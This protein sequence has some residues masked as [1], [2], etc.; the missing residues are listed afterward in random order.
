M[1]KMRKI[2]FMF[3]VIL[4]VVHNNSRK[5]GLKYPSDEAVG[6][7]LEILPILKLFLAHLRILTLAANLKMD[8]F[9]IFI[10]YEELD[11]TFVL[12][13]FKL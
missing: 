7:K 8:K 13:S 2:S 4:L 3:L 1:E 11:A 6:A 5:L 12:D 9:A 10:N